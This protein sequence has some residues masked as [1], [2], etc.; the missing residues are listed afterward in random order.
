MRREDNFTATVD[1]AAAFERAHADEPHDD[2][3]TLADVVD[4]S[5]W[6]PGKFRDAS[7]WNVGRGWS[8]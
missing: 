8:T 6:Y 2:R 7:D 5:G 4:E 1:A 3:P